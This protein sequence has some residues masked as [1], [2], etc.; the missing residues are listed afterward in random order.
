[1][2][3]SIIVPTYN[4]EKWIQQCVNSIL[5]QSYVDFDLLILDSGSTDGTL[6]WIR[7]IE[8]NRITIYTTLKRLG[9]E[10]NWGRILTVPRNEYM[11]ILGHDDVL[12]P[13]FLETINQLIIANPGASLYHTHFDLI[14]ATGKVIRPSKPMQQRYTGDEL[15]RAILTQSIDATA[16]GYVIRTRDYD[17]LK[18]I[19]LGYP[20]LMF[21]DYELWLRTAYLS[22]E[23]VAAAYCCAFRVHQST[24]NTTPDKKLHTALERF[25]D[26][27]A[28]LKQV[29]ESSANIINEY[30]AAFLLANGTSYAHRLLRTPL[31]ERGATTVDGFIQQTKKMAAILGVEQQYKPEASLSIKLTAMIDNNTILRKLFLLFKKLYTRPIVK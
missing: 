19:P 14:S 11:T 17:H 7:Y 16:T 23:V 13:S 5:A 6:P 24:T 8:D 27:L 9:I 15:L 3:F 2:K 30:G 26:F 21:A 31:K 28:G 1:M 10:D 22:Y 20:N 18:G 25:V 4:S 12:Y 29:N